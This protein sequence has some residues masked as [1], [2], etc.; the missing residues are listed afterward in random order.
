MV[1]RSIGFVIGIL[2][3]LIIV[4][5]LFK[6]ANRDGKVKTEYD[7]RQKEIRGRAYKYAF[8]TEMICQAV[9]MCLLM[10]GLELPVENYALL[11]IGVMIG[12]TVLAAYCIWNDVY[13]GLN[14][15][16]KRYQIIFAIAIVLNFLPVF[17]G[18][19]SGTLFENGKI[20]FPVLNITVLVMMVIIFVEMII[21]K[22]LDRKADKEE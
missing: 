12:C 22:A 8:Y 5:C 17:F 7:E 4:V 15:D 6:F 10:S 2:V 13:W 9:I 16:H 14:N 11:F 3:G 21:K 20:G 18:A 1:Y 19:K